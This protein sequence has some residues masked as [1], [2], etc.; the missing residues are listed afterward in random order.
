MDDSSDNF[1]KNDKVITVVNLLTK[2][3]I[4]LWELKDL[5]LE[6]SQKDIEVS[7]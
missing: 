5:S 1:L 6:E 4:K 7:S 3:K 2:F